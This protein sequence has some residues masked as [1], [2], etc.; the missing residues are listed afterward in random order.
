MA[1]GDVPATRKPAGAEGLGSPVVRPTSTPAPSQRASR[2]CAICDGVMRPAR[3][4]TKA[5]WRKRKCCSHKC[6]SLLRSEASRKARGVCVI[7]GKETRAKRRPDGCGFYKMTKTCGEKACVDKVRVETGKRSRQP[8]APKGT[9]RGYVLPR[10]PALMLEFKAAMLRKA[11]RDAAIREQVKTML[12]AP[13]SD[14]EA[15]DVR[16][17]RERRVA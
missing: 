13:V 3:S 5:E 10:D 11:E 9:W 1:K 2:R 7:C 8:K 4:E 15:M 12:E 16:N 14:R 6:A 17:P